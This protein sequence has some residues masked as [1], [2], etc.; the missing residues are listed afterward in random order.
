MFIPD[1]GSESF[2]PGSRIQDQKDSGSRIRV[3]TKGWSGMFI[4]NPGTQIRIP[5]TDPDFL[6]SR[7]P[8]LG[9][10]KAPN[11]GSGSATL[12]FYCLFSVQAPGHGNLP[13]PEGLLQPRGLRGLPPPLRGL[14]P[15]LPLPAPPVLEALQRTPP[16][17]CAGKEVWHP[18]RQFRTAFPEQRTNSAWQGSGTTWPPFLLLDISKSNYLMRIWIVKCLETFLLNEDSDPDRES[19]HLF[20]HSFFMNFLLN[21]FLRNAVLSFI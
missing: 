19:I 15:P 9:V 16:L 10:K 2:H 20:E 12:L 6:P 1:P 4:P 18:T 11:P 14:D 5:D 8:D 3:R 21:F 17:Q 7:I 13:E